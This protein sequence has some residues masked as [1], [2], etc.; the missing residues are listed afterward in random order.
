VPIIAL[1]EISI[2]IAQFIEKKREEE[3]AAE[4]P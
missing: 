1:Y 2:F 4:D 3:A